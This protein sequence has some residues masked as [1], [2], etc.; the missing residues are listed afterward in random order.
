[1]GQL[2]D[3]RSQIATGGKKFLDVMLERINTT[4]MQPAER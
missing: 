4:T 2:N 3:I 1:M